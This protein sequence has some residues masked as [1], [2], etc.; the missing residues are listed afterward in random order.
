MVSDTTRTFTINGVLT[1]EQV[2]RYSDGSTYTLTKSYHSDGSVWAQ[3]TMPDGKKM[4]FV[5]I[6]NCSISGFV[7]PP[8]VPYEDNP[9]LGPANHRE[10][11]AE[12]LK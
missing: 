4:P 5:C 8:E 3:Q 2:I 12:I 6:E 7:A 9:T 11:W 10:S 1:T